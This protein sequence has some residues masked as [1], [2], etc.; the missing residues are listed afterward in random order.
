MSRNALG[1]LGQKLG[2][3]APGRPPPASWGGPLDQSAAPPRS[4]LPLGRNVWT[5]L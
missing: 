4:Q 3:S 1:K 2:R 5:G